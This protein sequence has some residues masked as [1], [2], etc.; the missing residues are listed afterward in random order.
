MGKWGSLWENHGRINLGSHWFRSHHKPGFNVVLDDILGE[1]PQKKITRISPPVTSTVFHQVLDRQVG[2]PDS[3]AAR[4]RVNP[5]WMGNARS[6]LHQLKTLLDPTVNIGFNMF[7]PSFRWWRISQPQYD[8]DNHGIF[9]RIFRESGMASWEI[10]ELST[11]RFLA[12]K[13]IGK[14]VDVTNK[15]RKDK[16][17]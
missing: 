16:G 11:W 8:W 13:I 9:R 6:V 2:G 10:P 17:W 4:H 12:G 5:R 14:M 7:Q 1:F 3:K 15:R